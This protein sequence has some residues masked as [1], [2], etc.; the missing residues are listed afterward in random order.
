MFFDRPRREKQS[1]W[2]SAFGHRKVGELPYLCAIPSTDR[3]QMTSSKDEKVWRWL[4]SALCFQ[5]ALSGALLL[6]VLPALVGQLLGAESAKPFSVAWVLAVLVACYFVGRSGTLGAA[7]R[8]CSGSSS[9]KAPSLLRIG[10][11]Q[12]FSAAAFAACGVVVVAYL[13]Q[14]QQQ[15]RYM[16]RL[17]VLLYFGLFR[18]LSGCAAAGHR[19]FAWRCLDHAGLLEP[20]RATAAAEDWQQRGRSALESA[21]AVGGLAAGCALAGVLYDDYSELWPA[22]FSRDRPTLLLLCLVAAA[23]AHAPALVSV[24]LVARRK[25]CSRDAAGGGGGG[26][27]AIDGGYS[28]VR[29]TPGGSDAEMELMGRSPWSTPGGHSADGGRVG[30][31]DAAGPAAGD[32]DGEISVPGRYLRGCKG[33]VQEAERRW[34]LTLEWREKERI[35]EVRAVNTTTVGKLRVKAHV[36]QM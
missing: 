1:F 20:A 30:A 16:S 27:G 3:Q 4:A 36:Y 2:S 26:G 33:D 6:P 31:A 29:G 17:Y 34:R 11:L 25:C 23:A 24:L 22:S 9:G 13:Q 35:D 14:Q 7:A 18:A 21:G 12:L 32:P 10:V 28:T 8:L 19:W 15:Q 5:D